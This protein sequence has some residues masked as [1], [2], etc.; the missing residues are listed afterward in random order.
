MNPQDARRRA[1]PFPRRRLG[2]F[3]VAD[4]RGKE[5]SAERVAAAD[6]IDDVDVRRN[7][8]RPDVARS[9]VHDEGLGSLRHH[10]NAR[11]SVR[12]PW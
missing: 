6:A 12:A 7:A 3:S 2:V 9:V 4:V 1:D 8:E 10:H 11:G 5:R